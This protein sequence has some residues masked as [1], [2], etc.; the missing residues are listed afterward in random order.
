[1]YFAATRILTDDVDGLVGF[2]ETVTGLRANRLHPLFAEFTTDY[3]T[4][5]IASS[6]TIKAMGDDVLTAASNRSVIL[7]FL[8]GDVDEVH[9]RLT[10]AHLTDVVDGFVNDGPT[11]MPWGNRSLLL[12]D[13]DGN[14][15]NFYAPL[16]DRD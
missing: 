3:G 4:L 2:Y 14:L 5:A 11:D 12:R 9:R 1:M 7:D 8:V 13:P 15:V 10:N 16:A 6:T